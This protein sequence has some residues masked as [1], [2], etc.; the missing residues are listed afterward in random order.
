LRVWRPQLN[1]AK[2]SRASRSIESEAYKTLQ[3]FT[4]FPQWNPSM[5]RLRNAGKSPTEVIV[6]I[7]TPIPVL[8][9]AL[10]LAAGD[11]SGAWKAIA[12][13]PGTAA[14][15]YSAQDN[16]T[17]SLTG[18]WQMSWT[19]KEGNQKQGTMQLKQDGSKLS[20]SVRA[21]RGTFSLG[22]NLQGDQ[23]SID[24][25]VPLHKISFTGKVDG[26]KMSGTTAQ[27]MP[28]SAIRQ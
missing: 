11:V 4:K 17:S 16:G 12:E 26:T 21:Q 22:G 25:K 2:F 7:I 23:V 24:V 10:L 3:V 27:G 28:W 8:L 18:T 13:P 6:K 1:L 20:G 19:N 5:V 9:C 15:Q 14:S